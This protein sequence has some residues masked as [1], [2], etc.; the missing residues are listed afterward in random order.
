[1]GD[2]FDDDWFDNEV[3]DAID[4]QESQYINTQQVPLPI[5]ISTQANNINFQQSTTQQPVLLVN[6]GQYDRQQQH[7]DQV[8]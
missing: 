6:N 2:E 5:T 3:L 4:Q 7:Y 8:Q 1:M